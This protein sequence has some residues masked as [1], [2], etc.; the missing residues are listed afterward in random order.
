MKLSMR[1]GIAVFLAVCVMMSAGSAWAVKIG[2]DV[3]SDED[4]AV[5]K[6][7]KKDYP[8]LLPNFNLDAP[9]TYERDNDDLDIDW[10]FPPSISIGET[11]KTWIEDGATFDEDY[12]GCTLVWFKS[13]G[14]DTWR[15]GHLGIE[16]TG[17]TTFDASKLTP[18][19]YLYSLDFWNNTS[20]TTIILPDLPTLFALSISG[21]TVES[22][23][24]SKLV[25]LV[26]LRVEETSVK[27]L[28]LPASPEFKYLCCQGNSVLAELSGFYDKEVEVERFP[29]V[30][31]PSI[32]R[33]NPLLQEYSVTITSPENGTITKNGGDKI[34]NGDSV[35]FTVKAN[36]SYK[37]GAVQIN[38]ASVTL[39]G[40]TYTH[41]A[42][43]DV[44]VSAIFVE[45]N[46]PVTPPDNNND[47]KNDN[48]GGGGC[49]AGFGMFGLL[50]AGLAILKHRKI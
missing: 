4:L 16:R 29:W 6:A 20:L 38:G 18:L 44:E 3:Y 27:A 24:I 33:A 25:N 7:I 50:L 13:G 17:L 22:V 23:D 42:T 10:Q 9:T 28:S 45:D 30:D 34:Y 14:D 36:S 19:Q 41:K 15:L 35:T 11:A 32:F 37:L 21:K 31:T 46:A 39:T 1:V 40:E 2:D 26:S 5:I 43:S 48:G 49:N 12:F 47:N 8:E